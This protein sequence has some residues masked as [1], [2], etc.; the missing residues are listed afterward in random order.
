M[1]YPVCYPGCKK[2]LVDKTWEE[3]LKATGLEPR[4][5]RLLDPMCGSG[6]I[7][8]YGR[9]LG[10]D[11]V[12]ASDINR[13]AL[14]ATQT[15]MLSKP[16][17]N[18]DQFLDWIKQARERKSSKI[19]VEAFR[20]SS[21]ECFRDANRLIDSTFRIRSPRLSKYLLHILI[22]AIFRGTYSWAR[23]RP[24]DP[25]KKPI[26][27]SEYQRGFVSRLPRTKKSVDK[28]LF[29][30]SSK[31]IIR[32][33]FAKKMIEK[34]GA[35]AN[36]LYLDPPY[37][38]TEAR[39]QPAVLR[40][41]EPRFRYYNQRVG[42]MSLDEWT[43]WMVELLSCPIPWAFFAYV[44]WRRTL[45]SEYWERMAKRSSRKLVD[46]KTIYRGIIPGA[47]R[48]REAHKRREILVIMKKK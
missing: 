42:A 11:L 27:L 37:F 41:L 14:L 12:I 39:L 25:S 20:F 1:F 40:F 38:E 21:D 28:F 48:H 44:R 31:V 18:D 33:S 4:R 17:I 30:S 35:R 19:Y 6:V 10:V 15:M 47:G 45:R 9:N 32:R 36:V 23:A 24:K 29:P 5:I 8:H 2:K 22:Q 43:G 46:I 16:P 7:A 3:I 26:P 34:Y 13:Y